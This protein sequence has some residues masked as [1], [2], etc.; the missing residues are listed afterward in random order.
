MGRLRL[1]LGVAVVGLAG[2]LAAALA[3]YRAAGEAL[4]R[5]Q[6]ARLRGVGETASELLRSVPPTPELLRAIMVANGLDGAYVISPGLVVIA[7]AAG[8]SGAPAD[9]L[10]VDAAR[11]REAAAGRT[12]IARAYDVGLLAVETAYFPVRAADGTTA[13]VLALEAGKT[14]DAARAGLR[15]AFL[16]GFGLATAGAVALF[17]VAARASRVER[18]AREAAERAARGEAVARMAAGVAHEIRNPLGIIRGAVELVREREGVQLHPRDRERLEDVLGEVERL[19]GLTED[20]LDL[21]SDRPLDESLVDLGAIADEAAR[22]SRTLHPELDVFVSVSAP[23]IRADG[24]RLRQVFSN[25]LANA[26]QAGARRVEIRGASRGDHVGVIVADDGPG[27]APAV[28]E[29]LFEAF[30]TGRSGGTGLGLAVSRQLV[31]RHGGTLALSDEGGPG[32][33]F[34][35]RLPLRRVARERQS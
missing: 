19:R 12:T 25:L 28:R 18:R 27:I 33:V 22:G 1:P 20:F 3:L 23:P 24:R 16:L 8:P 29:R 7:D 17:G 32:A 10:R 6:E 14:F 35:V 26:A 5:V 11:V 9:L 13:R 4:D 30:A 34:E 2:S 15:R 21:S 31:E